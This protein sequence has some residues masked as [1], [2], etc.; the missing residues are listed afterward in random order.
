M[1]VGGTSDAAAEHWDRYAELY[2]APGGTVNRAEWLLHPVVRSRHRER[3][4]GRD[5]V[6]WFATDVLGDRQIRRAAGI[7]SGSAS[8]ELG[9]LASG[10]VERYELFEVSTTSASLARSLATQLGVAHRV[11][12]WTVDM[13]EVE[14]Q[15]ESYDLITFVSSLH[16]VSQLEPVCQRM[17]AALRPGGLLFATEY[18]GANRFAF[19]PQ[20]N[21]FARS[22][23]R[24]LESGLTCGA[25][26]LPQPDP[27]EVERAD[28]SEAVHS[29][30]ILDVLR[31]LFDR[32]EVHPMDGCLPFTL[33]WGLNYDALYDTVRGQDLVE[34]ICDLDTA[35]TAA[36]ALPVYFADVVA[37]V[38]G[39]GGP[40]P[41]PMA[42]LVSTQGRANAQPIAHGARR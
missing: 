25:T 28:P 24:V 21:A 16:H 27:A 8:F 15:S 18:V 13:N 12:F 38:D 34:L 7:G 20:H 26:E 22:M 33:W 23:Y 14:L 4:G 31:D 9:L 17:R 40:V 2:L 30:E 35:L 11:N 37:H 10:A 41:Q 3:R 5:I 32:V 36:G 19:P 1:S 39:D 29:Q 42:G 6:D